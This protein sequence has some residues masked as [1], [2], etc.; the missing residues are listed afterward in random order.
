MSKDNWSEDKLKYPFLS[1]K[2][3]ATTQTPARGWWIRVGRLMPRGLDHWWGFDSST[4]YEELTNE[5]IL[6]IKNHV[7]EE[8]EKKSTQ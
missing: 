5:I 4:N 3:S 1:N 8:F 7:I 2:P 6:I